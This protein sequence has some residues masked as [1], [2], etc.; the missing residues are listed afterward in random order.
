MQE[1][2]EKP[3]IVVVTDRWLLT[4]IV[5]SAWLGLITISLTGPFLGHP[6]LGPRLADIVSLVSVILIMLSQLSWD[7]DI[8]RKRATFEKLVALF[9]GVLAYNLTTSIYSLFL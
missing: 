6:L 4:S 7:A 3:R 1:Y 2:Q 9:L 5:L 8:A